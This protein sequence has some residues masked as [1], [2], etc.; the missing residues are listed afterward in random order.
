MNS[1]SR[2]ASL[3]CQRPRLLDQVARM[4]HHSMRTDDC[5]VRWATRF[6][7]SHGN[8]HLSGMSAIDK[9]ADH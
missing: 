2:L 1:T 8:R 6:L 9:L 5:Y 4:R 7:C 3:S